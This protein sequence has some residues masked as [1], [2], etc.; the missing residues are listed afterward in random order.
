MSLLNHWYIACESRLLESK[1]RQVTLFNQ[2]LVLWRDD[3]GEAHAL[4]DRC[5]HRNVPLSRGTIANGRLQCCYHGWCYNG[6]GE[7]THV[8]ALADGRTI[9]V[10]AQV[11]SYPI[12][13]QQG[14]LWL[15]PGDAPPNREPFVFPHHDDK[16]WTTFRMRTRFASGVEACLENFLDCPH[17]AHVHRGWFRNPDPRE[18]NALVRRHA[19]GVDVEFQNEP[20]TDSLIAR[21]LYPKDSTL[22]HVDRFIMPNLSRVDYV[23]SPRHHFIVTS[24]CTPVTDHETEVFTVVSFRYGAIGWL[25]RLFFEPM[26]RHIIQQDVDI[27]K[28]HGEN[29][30][31]FDGEAYTHVETDLISLHMRSLRRRA[32]TGGAAAIEPSERTIR[33]RF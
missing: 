7:C 11:R 3:D 21:L 28:T 14:Y 25:V 24:Q 23:F 20:T 4:I 18:M 8:P 6:A 16:E 5:A 12:K 1:P 33:I 27:L 13:E 29:V 26:S 9:P 32:D 17:T 2:R 30:R 15:W 10:N 22:K 19:E 31:R